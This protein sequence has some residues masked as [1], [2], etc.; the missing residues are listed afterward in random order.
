MSA[1]MVHGW[2]TTTENLALS[3][4][5]KYYNVPFVPPVQG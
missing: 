5:I 3:L 2:Y 4:Y 1:N